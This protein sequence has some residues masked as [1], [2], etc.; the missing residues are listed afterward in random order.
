MLFLH[1][2]LFHNVSIVCYLLSSSKIASNNTVIPHQ[3]QYTSQL[4][5]NQI[6]FYMTETMKTLLRVKSS[7]IVCLCSILEDLLHFFPCLIFY[8]SKTFTPPAIHAQHYCRSGNNLSI[9][10]LN[11]AKDQLSH[12]SETSPE[13]LFSLFP[14]ILFLVFTQICF[15]SAFCH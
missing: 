14:F 4:L 6:W 3:S 7:S 13:R 12:C 9:F 11:A 2:I 5:V 10:L 1:Y 8:V 15:L